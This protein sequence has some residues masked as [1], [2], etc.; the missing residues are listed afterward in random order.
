ME[1]LGMRLNDV[2]G[3]LKTLKD[4]TNKEN[5]KIHK[6]FEGRK[7]WRMPALSWSGESLVR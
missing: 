7:H 2:Y 1:I 4:L 5:N 6:G 3:K